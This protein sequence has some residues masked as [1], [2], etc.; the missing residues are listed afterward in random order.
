VAE[1]LWSRARM[2]IREIRQICSISQIR[3]ISSRAVAAKPSIE[4]P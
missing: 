2:F 3:P 4:I 1:V